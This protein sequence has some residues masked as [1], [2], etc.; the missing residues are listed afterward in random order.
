[1]GLRNIKTE[2]NQPGIYIDPGSSLAFDSV[3]K[4]DGEEKK[5]QI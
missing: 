2:R 4:Q 5:S 1:M 3:L